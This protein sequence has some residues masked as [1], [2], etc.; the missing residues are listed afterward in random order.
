MPPLQVKDFPPSL[1]ERLRQ[2]AREENRSI[3]QQTITIVEDYLD[4][5]DNARFP[6][7]ADRNEL[8]GAWI[9]ES[10]DIDYAAKRRKALERIS[11]HPLPETGSMP[12]SAELIRQVREEEA[13]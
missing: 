8:P 2:C 11:A 1:Y 10:E 6:P 9:P 5:R 13:R 12:S 7:H 4:M 3:S